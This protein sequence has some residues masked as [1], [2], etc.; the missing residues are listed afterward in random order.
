MHG[1]GS[2]Q[3]VDIQYNESVRWS[4]V[5]HEQSWRSNI[6]KS[7][8][9]FVM[10][11][12]LYLPWRQTAEC[13]SFSRNA[14]CPRY[15]K[16]SCRRQTARYFVSLNISL[17]HSRSLKVIRNGTIR[18]LGYG[19]LFAFHSKYGYILY[20]FRDKASYWS[21][22]KIFTARYIM[23]KRGICQHAVS[24]CLSV[25]LSRSWVAPKRIK[26]SSN[27]FHHVLAKPV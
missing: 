12:K 17:S 18:K 14:T 19:F 22:I 9:P 13:I 27:F 8:Q 15:K 20:C 7:K 21:N 3:V 26:V 4:T 23:H 11:Y 5:L 6:Y 25:R 24:V 2:L 1:L 10:Q 16:L